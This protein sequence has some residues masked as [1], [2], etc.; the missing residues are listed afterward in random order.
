MK[1]LSTLFITLL[2]FTSFAQ[3]P[4]DGFFKSKNELDLAFSGSYNYAPKYYAGTKLINYARNQAIV[5]LYGNYGLSE[6]WN[7]ILSLPLINFKPQDVG[8]YGKFKL[9]NKQFKKSEWSVFPTMGVSLP[10]WKYETQSGQAIGQRA[11]QFQP[12]LVTQFKWYKGLFIQAQTHYNYV[13]QPVPSSINASIK[14]GFASNKFYYDLWYDYQNGFG[15]KDYLGPVSFDSFRELVTSYQ[16]IG[17]V[18]YYTINEKWGVFING[19]YTLSG[20]NMSQATNVGAGVVL[21]LKTGKK[22][23]S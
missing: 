23:K 18:V 19:S 4:V 8:L 3:G 1:Y 12:M 11:V 7:L 21:K 22:A 10:T 9:I 6:R 2:L 16:R 13:L 5:S 17:G 15:D 14:I 20:R